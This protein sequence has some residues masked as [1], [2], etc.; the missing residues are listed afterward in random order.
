[1]IRVR[2]Q[3]EV[4]ATLQVESCSKYDGDDVKEALYNDHHGKC[5]LCEEKTGKSFQI[6]H[7]RPK[8]EDCFPELKYSWPNL[9]LSCPY[10]N[11]RKSNK[12]DQII[13][14]TTLNIEDQI[15]QRVDF[16]KNKISFHTPLNSEPIKQTI[17][18]LDKL[19]NGES[20]LRDF[21]CKT[22]YDNIG[23]EVNFFLSLLIKYKK[24]KCEEN[25]QAIMDSLTI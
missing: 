1:M 20:G 24:N 25:R 12:L 5:Y 6:E 2:K 17:S 22:L 19:M 8:A 11:G 10:C 14:P 9:F 21:K 13:D 16:G 23:R 4:P 3:Q 18:L 7:L 15:E